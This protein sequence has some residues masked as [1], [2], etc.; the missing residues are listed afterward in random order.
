MNVLNMYV[1]AACV[2]PLMHNTR[3]LRSSTVHACHYKN[4]HSMKTVKPRPTAKLWL[5]YCNCL[6][7]NCASSGAYIGETGHQCGTTEECT[8]YF[9]M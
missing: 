6:L 8:N 7:L 1:P 4:Y 3:K 9:N 2:E 5:I